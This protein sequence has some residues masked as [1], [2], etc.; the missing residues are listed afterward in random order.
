MPLSEQVRSFSAH[1]QRES[2]TADFQ[3]TAALLALALAVG[4]AGLNYPF[5]QLLLGLATVAAAG[6]FA[7]T[8]RSWR[9]TGNRLLA[10]ILL[11][12]TLTLPLLQ[13]IP[14][15]P[16]IWHQLPGREIVVE[17]DGLLG[18]S[19]WRPITLDVEGTIRSYLVLL[20]AAMLFVACLFLPGPS[21]ERLLW[22]VLAFA[23]IGSGLALVQLVS[24][25][26]TTIYAS[27]HSGFP[28]GLFVN[29]NHQAS[30][31]LVSMPVA[32]T[33][34]ALQL[35]RGKPRLPVIIAAISAIL[36]FALIVISTT[37]R[38]GTAL[39]PIAFV[40]ALL[41][42]FRGQAA[43]RLSLPVILSLAAIMLVVALSGR[44]EQTLAR[45]SGMDDSRFGFWA[46]V[47]W[48]LERYMLTGTG[49]GTFVPV[50]QIAESLEVLR[51]QFVNHAH[52]DY[53]EILLEGGVSGAAL[54]LLFFALL[55]LA[56]FKLFRSSISIHRGLMAAAGASGIVLLL[57]SSIVDY[58]LR[59]PA[60]AAPFA[61]FCALLLPR[62]AD[63]PSTSAQAQPREIAVVKLRSGGRSIAFRALTIVI[64]ALL[65]LLMVQAAV[66]SDRVRKGLF[67]SASSWAP[68]STRANEGASTR[69]LL[70]GRPEVALR[71]AYA[72]VRL[73][74]INAGA[75]RSIGLIED[76]RGDPALATQLM[77]N[78]AALGWRDPVVQLWIVDRALRTGEAATAVQR[79]EGL[80]QQ[81]LFP[82]VALALLLR[83]PN[84]EASLNALA[85]SLGRQPRW[86]G[87]FMD[88]AAQAE[89]R[90]LPALEKLF[91]KIAANPG[92]LTPNDS[93]DLIDRLVDSGEFPRAQ[94][95]WAMTRRGQLVVNGDFEAGA[96]GTGATFTPDHWSVR[97][98]LTNGP[99][100]G[101]APAGG[102]GSALQISSSN[103]SQP[104]LTQSL[105]LTPGAYALSVRS[106][107]RN[108]TS[109]SLSWQ[110][111]CEGMRGQK[112]VKNP[113]SNS[114][115]W[116]EHRA[117]FIVPIRDC[118]IQRLELGVLGDIGSNEIWIDDVRLAPNS[119]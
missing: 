38:M 44:M 90:D 26:G 17:L 14:L 110:I 109:L 1:P 15:P 99:K 96:S 19:M 71:H 55:A 81:G 93:E 103:A 97:R 113:L 68:W 77:S 92:G 64:L 4:G 118:P 51:P 11:G 57:L 89:A 8:Q 72:A 10:V 34:A 102:R 59:M 31:M 7:M 37:S 46:D 18:W 47:Q 43:W 6:Y 112:P 49:F 74:P 105:L 85:A 101:P 62:R 48:I 117:V 52:N 2:A 108:A 86:R 29:R 45:F 91:N 35:A 22:V 87:R 39:L 78:A 25:S 75:V 83:A 82:P 95:I 20:P 58:P 13:L 115:G 36:I 65:V 80:F 67:A 53:L 61:L 24:G 63:M 41:S 50:Y 106:Y 73:S 114:G 84:Q 98:G 33:V 28:I 88:A 69:A 60:L 56:S 119:H 9:F 70:E 42:L 3:M 104:I 30:F 76:M 54:I 79:A 100:V 116:Q 23:L 107:A 16:A 12:I 94:R 21:L 27:G 66:S 40:I 111:R 5:L 32:A